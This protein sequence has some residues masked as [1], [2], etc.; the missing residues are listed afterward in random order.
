[1]VVWRKTSWDYI[2][3]VGS[4]HL[5]FSDRTHRLQADWLL[6]ILSLP[7]VSILLT[8]IYTTYETWQLSQAYYHQTP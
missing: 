1:M 6:V 5:Y 7:R 3:E 4:H 2:P 8:E